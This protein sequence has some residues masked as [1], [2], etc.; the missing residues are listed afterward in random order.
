MPKFSSLFDWFEDRFKLNLFICCFFTVLIVFFMFDNYR[1]EDI[2]DPWSLSFSYNF[3]FKGIEYDSVYK[4][5]EVG[6]VAYFGKLYSYL[7]GSILSVFGW[8]KLNAHLISSALSLSALFLWI[9]SLKSLGFEHKVIVITILLMLVFE[10]YV[11]MGSKTRS[12][13]LAYFFCMLSFFLFI[14]ERYFLSGII[15]M[16][17]LETHPLGLTSFVYCLSY[18]IWRYEDLTNNKKRLCNSIMMVAVG[19]LVGL[20]IYLSLHYE[21]IMKIGNDIAHFSGGTSK[22]GSSNYLIAYFF[23][24]K[25]YRH[26][27]EA[28]LLLISLS[29]YF[30]IKLFRKNRFPLIFLILCAAQSLILLRG[31]SNY[32]V[33]FFP[34]LILF[35]TYTFVEAKRASLLLIFCF[36]LLIPQYIYLYK[37]NYRAEPYT[38]LVKKLQDVIPHDDG[39]PIFGSANEWFAFYDRNY[40]YYYLIG[41][42]PNEPKA[43]FIEEDNFRKHKWDV[44]ERFDKRTVIDRFIFND[45]KYNVLFLEDSSQN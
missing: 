3:L 41:E 1:Y 23:E 28:L 14:R 17:A 42:K 12:D 43:Y 10:P 37:I 9:K 36:C 7:Y 21:N 20:A 38:V 4:A 15:A 16:F 18:F 40:Y 5:Q 35:I 11:S 29:L 33:F 30:K 27:P 44:P 39:L 26:I 32:A 24:S 13:A 25:G 8:T 19:I 45:E 31:N 2:D 6:G 22:S 34:S